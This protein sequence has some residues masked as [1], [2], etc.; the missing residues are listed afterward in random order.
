MTTTETALTA[1]RKLV[2]LDTT[3]L[4][5]ELYLQANPGFGH[6]QWVTAPR[7][8]K[9]NWILSADQHQR[10]AQ[11]VLDAEQAHQDEEALRRTKGDAVDA[12]RAAITTT[13]PAHRIETRINGFK[14]GWDAAMLAL[15]G[16][17]TK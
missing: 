14:D 8:V 4:A 7:E 16:E 1:A 10:H 2:A 6:H 3:D 13:I 11:A 17:D 9:R 5:E 12:Y 15:R